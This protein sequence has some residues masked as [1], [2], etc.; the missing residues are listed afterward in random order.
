MGGLLATQHTL[1]LWSFLKLPSTMAI[2]VPLLPLNLGLLSFYSPSASASARVSVAILLLL[3]GLGITTVGKQDRMCVLFALGAVA[4]G[5]VLNRLA[6]KRS[7]TSYSL[8]STI[9]A[10][11]VSICFAR[12]LGGPVMGYQL[13]TPSPLAPAI[14]ASGLFAIWFTFTQ[15]GRAIFSIPGPTVQP[16]SVRWVLLSQYLP[17]IVAAF[18][19]IFVM[20]L[21]G[22]Y[23]DVHMHQYRGQ[24]SLLLV[25]L[26][27]AV[28]FVIYM[29]PRVDD[30]AYGDKGHEL[31]PATSRRKL[32]I[33][34]IPSSMIYILSVV[35]ITPILFLIAQ[36]SGMIPYR[37]GWDT[38][39]YSASPPPPIP[40]TVS[41][42]P[43]PKFF[44]S[45]LLLSSTGAPELPRPQLEVVF[46]YYNEPVDGLRAL[47]DE[48]KQA[49]NWWNTK[50]TV[51]HKG[52]PGDL[53]SP[54]NTSAQ[55]KQTDIL[56]E[57]ATL[58][59]VDE[60]V[61][62]ENIGRDG[63]TYLRHIVH[64]WDDLAYQ[65][66]FMQ[67]HLA[68]NDQF[69]ERLKFI[70]ERIGFMRFIII[71]S[72]R[73][74]FVTEEFPVAWRTIY[75][76]P[77]VSTIGATE[78]FR[79][80]KPYP[81]EPLLTTYH[82]QFIVSR[83]RIKKHPKHKYEKLLSMLEAPMSD[84]IH[85]DPGAYGYKDVPEGRAGMDLDV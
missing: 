30:E 70:H 6:G 74:D 62:L 51:Y 34:A 55:A 2:M 3:N 20:L 56:T 66:L 39:A 63:G 47:I 7:S 75:L 72:L 15:G 73:G 31:G 11:V 65:T 37:P 1:E 4:I 23:I 18:C 77:T 19:A 67:G 85:Q 58:S 25:L 5:A 22:S 82:G 76:S 24:A 40:G 13:Y 80:E 50:I 79:E 17:V 57:F 71:S 32:S 52:L 10:G 59:G 61:P 60:V 35:S 21:S 16:P 41:R 84:P 53:H 54:T 49:A 69:H 12:Y 9:I 45:P 36:Q 27:V 81:V 33:P 42:I 38:L 8:I 43:Y 48:I 68:F 78:S 14:V 64:H 46:A 44:D 26:A 29:V 83:E 28:A